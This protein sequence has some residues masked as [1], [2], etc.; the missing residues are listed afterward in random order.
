MENSKNSFW[1]FSLLIKD[2]APF[3]KNQFIDYLKKRGIDSRPV[4]YPLHQM[5]LY[6][7]F[8]KSS[9]KISIDI[10]T[11]GVS[12]PSFVGISQKEINHIL[13]TVKSLIDE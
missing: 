11:N 4:F 6:K 9:L 10:S 8:K 2:H 7:K 1:L 12:L 5:P 13:K 3:T